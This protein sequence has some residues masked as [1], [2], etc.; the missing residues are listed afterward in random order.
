[1]EA[2]ENGLN[3]NSDFSVSRKYKGRQFWKEEKVYFNN[4]FISVDGILVLMRFSMFAL[5]HFFLVKWPPRIFTTKL[6]VDFV[7]YVAKLS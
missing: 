4:I 3:I 7:T 1:M 2:S 6:L 5:T